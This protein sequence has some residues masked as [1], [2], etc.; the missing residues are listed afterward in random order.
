MTPY[1]KWRL[2]NPADDLQEV[3]TEVDETCGRYAEP[4]EDAPRG[5]KPTPCNG[6][7]TNSDG[8]IVCDVCGEAP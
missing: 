4:D 3:G 7:M 2:T 5:H 8:I 6:S 1:D